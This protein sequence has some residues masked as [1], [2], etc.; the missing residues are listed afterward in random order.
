MEFKS[1]LFIE[2]ND[3]PNDLTIEGEFVDEEFKIFLVRLSGSLDT[4]NSEPFSKA[5][6]AEVENMEAL[7]TIVLDIEGINYISSTGIGSIVD[8][9]SRAKNK[10]IELYI[11]KASIKI[12][13]VFSLLGFS[14]FLKFIENL[15]QVGTIISVFPRSV[16]CPF[17]ES[18]LK[19]LKAGRF[20]CSSCK[21]EVRVDDKANI[22]KI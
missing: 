11:Y 9:N 6:N 2:I 17:C 5:V 7:K 14:G 10:N 19:I 13:E 4:Y 1:Q 22:V 16:S 20:K 8:I 3:M 12:R 15:N 21:K 18:K